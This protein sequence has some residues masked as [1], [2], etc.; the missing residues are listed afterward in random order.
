MI[1]KRLSKFFR[2]NIMSVIIKKRDDV[3][4]FVK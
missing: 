2:I 1:L 4:F 3:I